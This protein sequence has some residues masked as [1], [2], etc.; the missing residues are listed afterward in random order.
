MINRVQLIKEMKKALD[1]P[2]SHNVVTEKPSFR[3][4][5]DEFL[6]PKGF[7]LK[8]G[9]QTFHFNVRDNSKLAEQIVKVD[10][11]PEKIKNEII[12]VLLC[13]DNIYLKGFRDILEKGALYSRNCRYY[14]AK[15]YYQG[16]DG[17]ED[18]KNAINLLIETPMEWFETPKKLDWIKE[19]SKR[20]DAIWMCIHYYE[21]K[22]KWDY[23]EEIQDITDYSEAF[24]FIMLLEKKTDKFFATELN[25]YAVYLLETYRFKNESKLVE[26]F[27]FFLLAEKFGQKNDGLYYIL[28][29]FYLLGVDNPKRQKN[30]GTP[31]INWITS[32]GVQK[33][34]HYFELIQDKSIYSFGTYAYLTAIY[35]LLGDNSKQ[36]LENDRIGA[37]K[38]FENSQVSYGLRLIRKAVDVLYYSDEKYMLYKEKPYINTKLYEEGMS[39]LKA[40]FSGKRA[41]WFDDVGEYILDEDKQ[42]YIDMAEKSKNEGVPIDFIYRL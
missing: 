14:L 9:K 2:E 18:K 36:A 42:K 22:I 7:D 24:P 20:E 27:N 16:G 30:E 1:L 13:E 31:G 19:K 40:S 38:K 35:R 4:T 11:V 23:N 8:C 28:G 39:Y 34:K 21:K 10:V 3:V 6:D 5:T 29:I 26:S 25:N 17:L 41:Y 12:A 37:E 33:A 32:E 15:D